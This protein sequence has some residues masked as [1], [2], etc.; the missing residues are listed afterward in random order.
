MT[1]ITA[2]AGFLCAALLAHSLLI[3]AQGSAQRTFPTPEDAVRELIAAAKPGKLDDLLAIFGADGRELVAS[4]DA[5]TARQNLE[6]FTVATTEGWR[7]VDQGTNHKVL[8]IGNEGWPF[9]VPIVKSA[10]SWKF[11]TAAGKEEVLARRIGRNELA[12][13]GTCHTYVEAQRDYAKQGHDGKPAGLFAKTFT[14]DPGKQNGLYWQA[15]R[16][17]PRSPL[18]DLVSEASQEGRQL[19]TDRDRP[20]PFHGYYFKILTGQ[21]KSAPGGAK[22]YIVNGEMSGGFALVAW[23]AQYDASGVMTFIVN[24]DGVV[25]QKDLGPKTDATVAAMTVYNPDASWR[26][27]Q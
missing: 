18:G 2:A 13:I 25:H 8:V 7:L 19:G 12:G 24:K 16:N 23:P 20:S 22:S 9:P 1:R 21:G 27:V 5:A 26:R 10:N 11:D 17:E 14:S 4:S 15:A 6:I 3:T